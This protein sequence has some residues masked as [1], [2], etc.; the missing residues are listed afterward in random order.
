MYIKTGSW[1]ID[2]KSGL[3][4]LVKS[5]VGE[6]FKE[7]TVCY[8]VLYSSGERLRSDKCSYKEFL[9]RNS[10]KTYSTEDAYEDGFKKGK[11]FNK[12]D[13]NL[14][15]R[16]GYNDG[17]HDCEASFELGNEFT[18]SIQEKAYDEGYDQAIDDL[19][20][21][22]VIGESDEDYS[23]EEYSEYE[24]GDVEDDEEEY[25]FSK[26]LDKILNGEKAQYEAEPTDLPTFG[27]RYDENGK[28][29]GFFINTGEA[30]KGVY[31]LV[32]IS[33]LARSGKDVAGE[34]ILGNLGEGWSRGAF[35]DIPKEMLFVMGVDT[36]C[37]N[38]DGEDEYY[39]YN[40]RHLMQSLG[41]D[42]GRNIDNDIWIKAFKKK[43]PTGNFV[44]T[45]VRM[46]N[47]ADFVR[48]NG[49]VIIHVKGRGGIKGN[50]Q[51]EAGIEIKRGDLIVF[52]DSDLANFEKEINNICKTLVKRV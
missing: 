19:I 26:E 29:C 52:N 47:E 18:D 33:G 42:W 3:E 45:D 35:A 13:Q 51:S 14:N 8:D 32:G 10:P 31:K 21:A 44:I 15:Y 22:G 38:K 7:S 20:E 48:D 23:D 43:N 1:W 46:E 30:S 50:H 28:F 11:E 4:V 2:D 12:D 41:T 36:K 40:I 16:M 27:G 17:W 6:S 9:Y 37:A 39:Q 5:I 49:G 25:C 34:I 24:F